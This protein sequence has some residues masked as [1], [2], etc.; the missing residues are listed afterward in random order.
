[1]NSPLLSADRLVQTYPSPDGG[2]V[3]AL[4]DVSFDLVRGETLGIV[5]A[6]GAGKSTLVRLLLGLE[7]PESGRI[8][9]DS[10]DLNQGKASLRRQRRMK[11]Q[12]VFQDPRSSLNP[13]LTLKSIVEEPLL[14]RRSLSRK[15]R[16]E[17]VDQSLM[18]VGLDPAF[19][20]RK[21]DALSGGERQRVAIARALITEPEILILDEP[22][23]ALDGPIRSQ[24]LTLLAEI[25]SS[26]DLTVVLVS[27]DVRSTKALAE[28]VVVLYAGVCVESGPA[29]E[30]LS[31]PVHPYTQALIDAIPQSDIGW[32]IPE[33]IVDGDP[34]TTGCACRK[35]CPMATSTCL[36]TP[37]LRTVRGEHRVACWEIETK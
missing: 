36:M 29:G 22:V 20:S 34:E 35:W 2:R 26:L 10:A 25:R 17:R 9:I 31:H 32:T 6:S 16:S 21:P 3:V 37:D 19:R 1:M 33:P 14:A 13:H 8:L 24:V 30:V 11:L 27:H 15:D 18:A 5:G 4:N 12:A 28:T 7:R 23:S